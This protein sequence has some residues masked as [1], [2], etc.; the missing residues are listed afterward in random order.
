MECELLFADCK[1]IDA[2]WPVT[3]HG[4]SALD[5]MFNAYD[6]R[7]QRRAVFAL[8]T[9]ANNWAVGWLSHVGEALGTSA[10]IGTCSS[11]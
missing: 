9:V 7:D 2:A 10:I 6:L 11:L 3:H 4:C 5:P 1:S 8:A